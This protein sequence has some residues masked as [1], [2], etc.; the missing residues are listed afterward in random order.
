MER[1]LE[2]L[3]LYVKIVRQTHINGVHLSCIKKNTKLFSE[4]KYSEICLN[5]IMNKPNFESNPNVRIVC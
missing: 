2:T 3:T 1:C 5:L 4:I